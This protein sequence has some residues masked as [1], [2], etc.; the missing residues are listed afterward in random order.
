MIKRYFIAVA[1]LL[2]MLAC[3]PKT[4]SDQPTKPV[5]AWNLDKIYEGLEFDMPKVMEP[6]FSDQSV[7]ITDFGGVPDGQTNNKEAFASAIDEVVKKGGGMVVVPRGIWLTGPITLKSN[8][9][10]HLEEGSVI[11]FSRD[12]DEYPLVK[13]SF[14]GLNTVRCMSPIN[15]TELENVAIT[16]K[17][18]I[19]GSGDAW[20][21]VKRS[22]LT[23]S[24]WEELISSGGVLNEQ[25]NTWYPSE[26]S[27]RGDTKDNFNVPKGYT[28]MEQYEEIKD[29]LRPVMISLVKCN[30]VLLDGPTFQNS[31]AWNIHPLMCEN[32]ILRNLTIRNPWYS[33]NGDGL[34][35]ESCK[36]S[37]VYNCNFDVGDDAICIKSGKNEDGRKRGMP[38]ENLVV[39]NNIVY[40]GHGGFVIGSEMSGGV[41]NVHVSECTFIGTDVGLRF[42]STR[43]RG[44]IVENIFISDID[45]MNIPTEAIR[46]NMYYTG[47][48][49]I[50]EPEQE[51]IDAEKLAAM[52][53]PVTEETPQFR[54][55]HIKDIVCKGAKRAILLQGLP[56]MNLQN[57]SIENVDISADLGLT[58]SD[59]DGVTMRDVNLILKEGLVMEFKNSQN[60]TVDGFTYSSPSETVMKVVGP[61]TKNIKVAN[62]NIKPDQVKLSDNV[63]KSEVVIN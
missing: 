5:K 12:F 16:G 10:L 1:S 30:K 4:N 55:I 51:H 19:D 59:A 57:V 60:V 20:R 26:K 41:K 50:S 38:T 58:C 7:S 37:I 23:E 21:M 52:M 3:Q 48:S 31:P 53:P 13:T 14:E 8:V 2:I 28:S 49:P 42:K 54:N 45:M 34:D 32:V 33:Q 56:E 43:G 61:F 18:I 40:H 29:F 35:L 24:Q 63:N 25:G 9:N 47:A 62:A 44:G 46:F 27:L 36:N 22:K 39:K 6:V 15:G 11:L 17:G